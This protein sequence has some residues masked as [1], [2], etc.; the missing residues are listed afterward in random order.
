M[1]AKIFSAMMILQAL[2]FYSTMLPGHSRA[3]THLVCQTIAPN[4]LSDLGARK[5]KMHS[6]RWICFG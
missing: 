1:M 3:I 2:D 5:P 6:I 4:F